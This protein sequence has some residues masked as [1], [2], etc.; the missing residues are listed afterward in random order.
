MRKMSV[1][2]FLNFILISA[3]SQRIIN[4]PTFQSQTQGNF[5]EAQIVKVELD[6]QKTIVEFNLIGKQSCNL[7]FSEPGKE[8]SIRIKANGKIYLL[9]QQTISNRSLEPGVTSNIITV[10]DPLPISTQNFDI[11]DGGLQINGIDLINI[12]S[13]NKKLS[14][15]EASSNIIL[16]NVEHNIHYSLSSDNIIIYVVDLKDND[17]NLDIQYVE[18][19]WGKATING[20]YKDI[21]SDGCSIEFD[22]NHDGQLTRTDKRFYKINKSEKAD[23]HFLPEFNNG[24]QFGR[25]SSS[26]GASNGA[27]FIDKS[28]SDCTYSIDN[29]GHLTYVFTIPLDEILIPDNDK[30]MFR[31]QIDRTATNPSP[32][33]QYKDFIY[34]EGQ[35]RSYKERPKFFTIDFSNSVNNEWL[36]YVQKRQ[37]IKEEIK[38]KT[39]DANL[40]RKLYTSEALKKATKTLSLYD[41]M[42]IETTLGSFIEVPHQACY[43]GKISKEKI[44]DVSALIDLNSKNKYPYFL[45]ECFDTLRFIQIEKSKFKS[46][47]VVAGGNLKNVI[48]YMTF[49]SLTK[50]PLRPMEGGN[51]YLYKAGSYPGQYHSGEV[52]NTTMYWFDNPKMDANRETGESWSYKY[53]FNQTLAEKHF[54]GAWAG[55]NIW[56]FEIIADK[57]VVKKAVNTQAKKSNSKQVRK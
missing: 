15:S 37:G 8:T 11:G 26:Y 50:Y 18:R 43:Y 57:P 29:N 32:N 2:L 52:S 19:K 47:R 45:E 51:V 5:A 46:I 7:S 30:L 54:Y 56:V 53:T 4:Y 10:F 49:H 23:A 40:L 20:A 1:Y 33:I 21:Y 34:P 12:G 41:G 27:A 16:K 39:S 9:K 14:N 28:K 38:I 55:D 31:V 24:L 6:E 22:I 42:Y 44:R 13:N 35:V 25:I 3:S 36:A 48:D 17:L